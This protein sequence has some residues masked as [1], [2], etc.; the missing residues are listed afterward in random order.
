MLKLLF[1]L[2]GRINRQRFWLGLLLVAVLNIVL[3]VL[4]MNL[5]F[6]NSQTQSGSVEVDG[7]LQQQFMRTVFV[8]APLPSLLL[9]LLSAV[10]M[11]ILAIKRRRDR[12]VSGIDVVVFTA[13]AIVTQLLV[14]AGQGGTL[15]TGIL[16]T[17]QGIWSLVLLVQLGFLSGTRG[18]NSYGP[19]P[20]GYGDA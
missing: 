1:S 4:L 14:L 5:G 9:S 6:G 18:P 13:L 7:Q 15:L 19:D 16:G 3:S 12:N 17:V 10:P 8:L 20:L 2:D 11:T